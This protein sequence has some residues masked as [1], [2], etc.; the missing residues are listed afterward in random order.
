MPKLFTAAD[1]EVFVVAVGQPADDFSWPEVIEGAQ[2]AIDY[3][4]LQL[5]FPKEQ[6]ANHWGS[7]QTIA[8]GISYE[9][10]QTVRLSSL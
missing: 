8:S 9:G 7:F 6:D 10:S 3:A 2:K 5:K 1:F 4:H